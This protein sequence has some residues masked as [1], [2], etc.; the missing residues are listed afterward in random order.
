MNIIA[1]IPARSG[2]KGVPNKNI[3]LLSGKPLISYSIKN[4]TNSKYISRTIVIS[5]SEEVRLI[6]EEYGVEFKN[7]ESDLCRDMI[8]LD[9][10]VCNALIDE[11]YDYAV[12][13][14]ATSPTL[15]V[16]TLDNAIKYALENDYDTVLSAVNH[17]KLG[18]IEKG[19]RLVPDYEKRLNR[20]YLPRHY[21]ETGAFVI[22]KSH[23]LD[24]KT[25][26]GEQVSVYEISDEESVDIDGFTDIVTAE[27]II[28]KK[29]IA[30][31]VN[32]NNSMGMGHVVRMLDLADMFYSKP[33]FYYDRNVTDETI[34]GNTTYELRSYG[35]LSELLE[36]LKKGEYNIVINDILNTDL[37]YMR[38]LRA[39]P[40][41]P[42]IINFEDVGEGVS[43]ADLVFNALYSKDEIDF[44]V[45]SGEDYY[46]VPKMF[47]LFN[48][49]KVNEAVERVFVCFGGADPGNYTECIFKII[50]KD[51]YKNLEFFIVI[52][53][54]KKNY[55]E[56]LKMGLD[57]IHFYYD[58]KSIPRLMSKCD[59]AVTSRGRTCYELAYLGIPTLSIA[60]NKTEMKHSFVSEE[61]GFIRLNNNSATDEIERKL[62]QLVSLSYSE[63]S[64]MHH[65]MVRVDLL[66]GRNRIRDMI[67]DL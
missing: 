22:S 30:I 32:G 45:Y 17:P 52:G 1:V 55:Q 60:Q 61:H 13:L 37:P 8:T 65:K 63:R 51:K 42:K 57:N 33:V 11:E 44:P 29:N 21:I 31:I 28:D 43:E 5:D 46:I 47:T 38:S 6:A 35:E 16:E 49:I 7:E 62:E 15:K 2:S 66:K 27:S 25:R 48:P 54:A 39:L 41:R 40:K 12:T 19:G 3:R 58:V 23:V 53:K 36:Y 14:Q 56:L 18:W 26:F 67:L 9:E 4:A 64:D 59:V 24:K 10:V 20:Q 34:F 50:K